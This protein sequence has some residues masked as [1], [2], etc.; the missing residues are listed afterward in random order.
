[1]SWRFDSAAATVEATFSA[2]TTLKDGGADLSTEP[3]LA[4]YRHQWLHTDAALLPLTYVSSRGLMKVHE[5]RAFTTRLP[6]GGVLPALPLNAISGPDRARLL[7]DL[8]A[9]ARGADPFP[10][11]PDGKRNTYW[12]GRSLARLASLIPIAAQ[13]GND[14]DAARRWLLAT[15]KGRLADWFDGREPLLFAYD[16]SWRTLVGLPAGFGSVGE[17]NDHHFHHGYFVYA[18]ALV[19]AYDRPGDGAAASPWSRADGWGAMVRLLVKDAANWERQDRRFPFLRNFDPYA[20]HAWAS[21]PAP[22]HDGNNEE[23]SSEEM[24]FATALVLFGAVTGDRAVRD[25]GA[26]LYATAATAIEQYWFDQDRQ[27]F[28]R[29]F[30]PDG[31]GIV[32]DAGGQYD[33]WWDRNP[34]FAVGINLLPITGGSLYLGRHP[35]DVQARYER[36]T[37]RNGG[38]ILQWRDVFWMYLALAD[39]PRAAALFERQRYFEPEFGDTVPFLEHW[40]SALAA[41]GQ[42]DTTVSADNALSATFRKEGRRTYVAFNPTAAIARVRFSDGRVL[43]VAPGTL[44]SAS[45]A[46]AADRERNR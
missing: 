26:F 28:P 38:E 36:L 23:S 21:G 16:P 13:L 33:T 29:A 8:A 7:R 35:A 32:W 42:V 45:T 18:A 14:A 41:L 34:V 46:L 17:L 2:E 10:A 40:L 22:F 4:L 9:T 25:L 30:E 5:G 15:V 43:D 3:L 31:V 37:R 1:V 19:A 44:G 24:N 20:G 11:G 27:V 6:F 12:D 39:A